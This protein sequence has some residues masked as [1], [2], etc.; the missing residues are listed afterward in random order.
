M[1]DDGSLDS[2]LEEPE[3]RGQEVVCIKSTIDSLVQQSARYRKSKQFAEMIEFISRFRNYAPYNSMLIKIQNPACSFFATERDW[4]K[5]F[6]R[7]L[8]EYARP[9]LILAPMHPV[10]LVYDVDQTKGDELPEKLRFFSNVTGEFDDRWPPNVKHQAKKLGIR[11]DC[12]TLSSAM[13]GFATRALWDEKHSMRIVIHNELDGSSQLSVICHELAH[14]LL[15]HLGSDENK[16]WPS[17]KGLPHSTME[18]EAEAVAHIVTSRIGLK[19]SSAAYLSSYI[20]ENELLPES[21]SLHHIS[22]V[23]GKIDA[24]ITKGLSIGS[25][26]MSVDILLTDSRQCDMFDSA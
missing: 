7:T 18:I 16:K 25:R 21:V 5:E 6:N 24:M 12:K 22:R 19:G 26:R 1:I 2:A 11:I 4:L 8:I 13:S 20:D 9:M 3:N 23:S 15:G 17:R 10:M 14:I